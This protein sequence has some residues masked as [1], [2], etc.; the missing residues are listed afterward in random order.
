MFKANKLGA[1]FVIKDKTR[2][3]H[4][5]DI[6]Y[7]AKCPDCPLTYIGESARRLKERIL[8]HSGRDKKSSILRHSKAAN[9]QVVSDN[10]FEIIASNFNH[11]DK[12]KISEALLIKEHLPPLNE[13]E[14][15][16]SLNLLN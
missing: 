11:D 16:V 13:Q 15:S 5:Y 7:K 14:Q 12:R 8:D 9:H 6:V 10:D 3:E 1:N 2:T 4:K